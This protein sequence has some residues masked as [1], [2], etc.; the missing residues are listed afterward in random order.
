MASSVR[1]H[2]VPL[3][4]VCLLTIIIVSVQPAHAAVSRAWVN[5]GEDKV[6]RDELRLQP[7]GRM[8]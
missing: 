8:Q 2:S 3:L 5:N 6:T 1:L 4:I 7:A